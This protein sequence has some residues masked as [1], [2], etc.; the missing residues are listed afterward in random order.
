MPSPQFHHRGSGVS[1]SAILISGGILICGQRAMIDRHL[2][3][4]AL[5][6]LVSKE[7]SNR[8]L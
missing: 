8:L 5:Q 3:N 1:P 7:A 6:P 2:W 4:A